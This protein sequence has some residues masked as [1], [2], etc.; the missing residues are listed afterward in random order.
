VASPYDL[1]EVKPRHKVVRWVN[2]YPNGDM[3]HHMTRESAE[4]TRDKRCVACIRVEF[5]Y[6][7][8]EGLGPVE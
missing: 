2:V 6:E 1:V 7:E 3:V 5:E 4:F 8:G